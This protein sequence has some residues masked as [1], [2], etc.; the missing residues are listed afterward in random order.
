MLRATRQLSDSRGKLVINLENELAFASTEASNW[1]QS[2]KE[3]L[4]TVVL[5]KHN[6][7]DFIKLQEQLA[8]KEAAVEGIKQ[9]QENLEKKIQAVADKQLVLVEENTKLAEDNEWLVS[10]ARNLSCQV[11]DLQNQLKTAL[12]ARRKLLYILHKAAKTFNGIVSRSY[13]EIEGNKTG[14][15]ETGNSDGSATSCAEPDRVLG[16]NE[17]S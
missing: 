4:E 13:L 7:E 1:K 5:Q 15:N 6:D 9:L 10:S 12:Y 17:K 8:A 16:G 3:A 14:D 11:A 2:W